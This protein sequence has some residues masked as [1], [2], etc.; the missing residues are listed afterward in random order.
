MMPAEKMSLRRSTGAPEICSGDMYAGV[1]TMVPAC[2]RSA[3]VRSASVTRATPKS[4]SLARALAV[5]HHVG[6]LD[7]AVDDAR[8]VREVE[9]VQ[10]LA[11]DAHGL[12]AVEELGSASKK[13][14]AARLPLMNSMTR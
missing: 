6:R 8:L 11:H 4:A 2:V 13:L 5:E 14:L 10:Q 12:L 9:R 7:V 3:L 1:P